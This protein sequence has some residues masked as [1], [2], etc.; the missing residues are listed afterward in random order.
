M[1]EFFKSTS[2][3][4]MYMVAPYVGS[5]TTLIFLFVAAFVIL[6]FDH[7]WRIP[8]VAIVLL[9][10]WAGMD[11][12]REHGQR[13]RVVFYSGENMTVPK[14]AFNMHR[15]LSSYCKNNDCEWE[16]S[17]YR[18]WITAD[19]TKRLMYAFPRI[20]WHKTVIGFEDAES[21]EFFL[22]VLREVYDVDRQDKR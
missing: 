4:G 18:C 9:G 21:R 10:I 14:W 2:K 22:G 6:Y 5:L 12:N 16:Q 20:P 15:K 7:G 17:F 1:T 19:G 8:L 3:Y 13:A 11:W